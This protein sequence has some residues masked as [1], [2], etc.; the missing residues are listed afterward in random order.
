MST[1]PPGWYKDPADPTTQRWW[2]GEGWLGDPIPADVTPPDGPPPVAPA[3]PPPPAPTSPGPAPGPV[4]ATPTGPGAPVA[5]PMSHRHPV[6]MPR[7]HPLPLA[8]V[9]ARFMARFV[10]ALV[11][12]ILA[13]VANVWFAV[14]FWRSFE[15]VLAWAMQQP[16]TWD[17]I[18][19]SAARASELLFLMGVVLTAV[20]FAYEVPASANTGQTLGKRIFGIRVVRED[21][22]ER[23]GFGR[24]LGRW[25]R[26]AWPTPFWVVCYGLPLLLQVADCLFIVMDNQRRQALHDRF[27][28]TL[29]VQVPRTDRPTRTTAGADG[30]DQMSTSSSSTGGSRADSR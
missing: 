21:S 28:R 30:S 7:P 23:L 11:I 18:P 1:I 6:A 5:W 2:D 25:F 24:S 17:A 15:P 26:L 13:A 22:D 8:G 3:P 29:V 16:L 4:A 10:D 19:P 27:A 12:L 20:W 9:G 14:E